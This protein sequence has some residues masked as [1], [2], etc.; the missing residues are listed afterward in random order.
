MN[1][2]LIVQADDG[3][4]KASIRLRTHASIRYHD[5]QIAYQSETHLSSIRLNR[6]ESG[7]DKEKQT[8]TLASQFCVPRQGS[9]SI[10]F[11]CL[12]H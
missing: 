7:D 4:I 9:S 12:S 11:M 8:R 10:H 3:A 5:S 6:T 2:H 1:F